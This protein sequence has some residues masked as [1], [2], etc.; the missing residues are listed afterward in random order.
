MLPFKCVFYE[1][2]FWFCFNCPDLFRVGLPPL[3]FRNPT[4]NWKLVGWLW[5]MVDSGDNSRNSVQESFSYMTRTHSS[6]NH[7]SH[8]N[9][10]SVIVY[11]QD[12]TDCI[13]ARW[14]MIKNK[15]K[16]AW[17]CNQTINRNKVPILPL[18]YQCK[19][20]SCKLILPEPNLEIPC[21]DMI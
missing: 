13:H 18:Q 10:A 4:H 20:L 2:F 5:E 11:T 14:L 17:H 8:T 3:I 7:F 19:D 6:F 15:R 12:S 16:L 21:H 1:W 9:D